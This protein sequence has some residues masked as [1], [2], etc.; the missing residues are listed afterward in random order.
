MSTERAVAQRAVPLE[1]DAKGS[2]AETRRRAKSIPTALPLK[3][4]TA[5]GD[6][7]PSPADQARLWL[8]PRLTAI[9]TGDNPLGIQPPDVF[10]LWRKH[11]EAAAHWNAPVIRYPRLAYGL[12]HT[13]AAVSAYWL[14]WATFS[15]AGLVITA[16]LLAAFIYWF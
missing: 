4:V 7:S 15:P 6:D 14:L 8:L 1:P 11:R 12:V 13:T 10:A 3:P 9:A 2:D 16:A 5:P